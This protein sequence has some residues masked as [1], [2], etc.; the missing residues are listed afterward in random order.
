M[1]HCVSSAVY[2]VCFFVQVI[3]KV[4]KGTKDD[5]DIAVE[6]AHV[7][8]SNVTCVIVEVNISNYSCCCST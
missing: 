7:S 6:A 1:Y 4:A 2:C 8:L 5:V 3:C